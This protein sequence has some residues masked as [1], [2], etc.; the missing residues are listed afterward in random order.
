MSEAL[1]YSDK[2]LKASKVQLGYNSVALGS[3]D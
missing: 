1:L 3:S 2:F